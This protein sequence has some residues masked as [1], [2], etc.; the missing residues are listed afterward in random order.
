METSAAGAAIS[1]SKPTSKRPF[2]Q[3]PNARQLAM[4]YQGV[5]GT[6]IVICP[7]SLLSQ[8]RDEIHKYS[9]LHAMLWY[10]D[11]RK[12]LEWSEIDVLIT[13]YGCVTSE[14]KTYQNLLTSNATKAEIQKQCPLFSQTWYR[15]VLDEAHVIRNRLTE[16]AKA[17]FG[18]KSIRRWCLTGTP[19]Q[20]SIDDIF[21]LLHFLKEDP[22]ADVG[23]WN[24][25]KI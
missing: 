21:S 4:N 7:M 2:F 11:N 8:W 22:W 5:M 13:S 16:T 20:N 19:I 17:I 9:D 3:D 6:T 10:G 23:W 14:F 18:L 12:A 25:G 1:S 15:V 24:A